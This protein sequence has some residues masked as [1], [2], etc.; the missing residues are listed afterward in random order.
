MVKTEKWNHFESGDLVID[1]EMGLRVYLIEKYAR[2][3]EKVD[4]KPRVSFIWKVLVSPKHGGDMLFEL[5][6]ETVFHGWLTDWHDGPVE[7]VE[8]FRDGKK[9]EW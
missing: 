1:E 8:H 5:W 2:V 9:I 6:G 3:M 4:H 7:G